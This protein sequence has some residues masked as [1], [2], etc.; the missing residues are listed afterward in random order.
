[1]PANEPVQIVPNP[2]TVEALKEAEKGPLP[3]FQSV[4]DLLEDLHTED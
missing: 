4:E 1:M 3:R 2:E